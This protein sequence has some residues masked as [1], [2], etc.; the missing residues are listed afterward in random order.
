MNNCS[1]FLN[2]K[3]V[4]N[5]GVGTMRAS[6][7]EELLHAKFMENGRRISFVNLESIAFENKLL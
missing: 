2:N 6:Y 3:L 5:I 4:N 1:L 7:I